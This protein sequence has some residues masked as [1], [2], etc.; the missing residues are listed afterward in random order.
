METVA[1]S[2]ATT[3][4]QQKRFCRGNTGSTLSVDI[5][6]KHD[7]RSAI[8]LP[9]WPSTEETEYRNATMTAYINANTEI[10]TILGH[11]TVHVT[12]LSMQ[13]HYWRDQTL[14][15]SIF[16]HQLNYTIL[17]TITRTVAN[18]LHQ[19]LTCIPGRRTRAPA[20]LIGG[21]EKGVRSSSRTVRK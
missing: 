17:C 9:W 20:V 8:Q 13:L 1:L 16:L 5:V 10:P 4:V 21:W 2:S 7:V 15:S 14:T 11:Y 12:V 6:W 18:K 19:K 3:Q